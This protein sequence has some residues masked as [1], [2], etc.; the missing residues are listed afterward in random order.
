MANRLLDL[1]AEE[2]NLPYVLC[3]GSAA[4]MTAA[5]DGQDV[6]RR[7]RATRHENALR[8]RSQIRRI[9]QKPL[10]GRL[11][12]IVGHHPFQDLVIFKLQP[13]PKTLGP[14]SAG[15]GL[16]AKRVRIRK[17][18]NEVN[19]L[20][21]AQ[22]DA[23]YIPR[24]VQQFEL[25]LVD[26]VRWRDIAIDR[27]AVH[28]ANNYFLVSRRHPALGEIEAGLVAGPLPDCDS[29]TNLTKS[30]TTR[31]NSS[32]TVN[33]VLFSLACQMPSFAL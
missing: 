27:I 25:A 22:I 30:R 7:Q 29:R 32:Q 11:G 6:E 24:R 28:F 33:G 26:K 4:T 18:T 5:D 20:N 3:T 23:Y 9:D 31:D 13:H 21:I 19:S 15:E 8:I 1:F 12:E 17:F 2:L 16:P 14:R 10:R